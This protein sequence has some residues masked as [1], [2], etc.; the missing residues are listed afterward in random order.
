MHL[1][2]MGKVV[3]CN[4]T[5]QRAVCCHAHVLVHSPF[6]PVCCVISS[7]GY[8]PNGGIKPDIEHLISE[9]IQGHWDAPFQVTSDAALLQTITHPSIGGLQHHKAVGMISQASVSASGAV[10][11]SCT[12]GV[13]W[14]SH[15]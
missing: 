7:N 8:V 15:C 11:H 12:L 2:A 1:L 4:A 3:C 13:Y 6:L 5:V 14:G 10:V 9:A